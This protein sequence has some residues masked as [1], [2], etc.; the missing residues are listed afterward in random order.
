MDLLIGVVLTESVDR[1]D[2]GGNPSEEGDLQ[3]KEHYASE[4]P[5]DGEERQPGKDES[6]E[7][8]HECALSAVVLYF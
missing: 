8:S 2:G 5:V 1:P 4:R 7:Q 6:D 3:K